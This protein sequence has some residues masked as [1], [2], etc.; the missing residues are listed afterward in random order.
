MSQWWGKY[1][2]TL[3]GFFLKLLAAQ[4][5]T[6]RAFVTCSLRKTRRTRAWLARY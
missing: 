5:T 4:T 6:Q 2:R 3:A 1:L